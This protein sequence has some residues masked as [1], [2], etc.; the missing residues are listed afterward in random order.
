LKEEFRLSFSVETF[1]ADLLHIAEARLNFVSLPHRAP[2]AI[3]ANA[4]KKAQ[5]IF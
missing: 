5:K 1:H 2:H 3:L 4:W